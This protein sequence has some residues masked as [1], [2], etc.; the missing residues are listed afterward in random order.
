MGGACR[1]RDHGSAAA[2]TAAGGEG[3]FTQTFR[4]DRNGA[5]LY[6]ES[7]A[8][9]YLDVDLG[10]TFAS[11]TAIRAYVYP[12][13]GE[14]AP[15]GTKLNVMWGKENPPSGASDYVAPLDASYPTVFSVGPSSTSG[16]ETYGETV[17][18]GVYVQW[19]HAPSDTTFPVDVEKV[20]VEVC[21]TTT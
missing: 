16:G 17:Q 8:F 12:R 7:S 19:L 5:A 4:V 11:V 15:A 21:G 9:R 2:S 3:C 13:G 10:V 18:D 1:R 14:P 6:W 20:V